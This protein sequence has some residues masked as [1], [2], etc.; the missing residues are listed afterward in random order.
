MIL[1]AE[2][3]RERLQYNPATGIFTWNRILVTDHRH[4]QWNVR[5]EGQQAGSINADGYVVIKIDKRQYYAHRLA[6]LYS[7][8]E[9]PVGLLDHWDRVRS[10][11]WLDNLRPATRS[12]NQGNT[13]IQKNNSSGSRGVR[14]HGNAWTAECAGQYLGYF[15]TKDEASSAYTSAASKHFGEYTNNERRAQ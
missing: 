7:H 9:W 6:W 12:Q 2:Y 8:G 13:D 11:N 5:Y 14:R 3:L 15:K 4:E 10:H 1:T